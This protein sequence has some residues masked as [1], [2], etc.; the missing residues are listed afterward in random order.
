MKK[1]TILLVLVSMLIATPLLADVYSRLVLVS[2]EDGMLVVDV[3]A[4]SDDGEPLI[5]LYRGAFKVSET[6]EKRVTYVGFDNLLFTAPEYITELGYSSEYRKFTWIY[7]YNEAYAGD[8]ESIPEEWTS[9]LRVRIMYNTADE[10]ASLS[11]AGSP[12][13]LVLDDQGNDITGDYMPIPPDLQD[14]PLPVEMQM[15]SAIIE[16]NAAVITWRT[17]TELNNLGFHI[18]RSDNPETDFVKITD[19]MIWGQGSTSTPHD[20][21]YVDRTV[22]ANS[23][24]WYLIETIST[25]GLRTFYGPFEATVSSAAESDIST[26]PNEFSLSP[27]YPNPFNPSTQIS[28][29]LPRASQVTLTIY[30]ILGNRVNSLVNELQPA[31]VYQVTWDGTNSRGQ[32][33]ESGIFI[34]ELQAG[35]QV[36]YQKMTMI[37]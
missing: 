28:Y 12:S 18:Y 37:K 8:Y 5:S 17:E 19:D 36:L 4:Q 2:N 13:Y 35:D 32:R 30:D 29:Q 14:F 22:E 33:L 7:T 21:E 23:D 15:Y 20:Y 27:N 34:Y 25:D 31:G 6:L 26:A 16:Q 10:I 24:Y 9:V 1:I 11:W 3:Q